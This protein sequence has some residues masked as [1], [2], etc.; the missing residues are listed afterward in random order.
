[1]IKGVNIDA[2]KDTPNEEIDQIFKELRENFATNILLNKSFRKTQLD[3]LRRGLEKKEKEITEAIY[4]DLKLNVSDAYSTN[5]LT[6]KIEIKEMMRNLD[7]WSKP[8]KRKTP[9]ALFPGTS[10]V[11]AQARGVVLVIGSW[12]Y[13]ISTLGPMVA[14]IAAGNCVMIKPSE[15]APATS[16]ILKVLCDE[17]LDT[18]FYRVVE[19][20]IETGRRVSSLPF[21]LICFTGSTFVGKIIAGCA[22]KNLTPCILELGGKCPTIVDHTAKLELCAK[23]IAS[24]KFLNSSQTCVAPD[25]IFVHAKI[26]TKFIEELKKQITKMYGKNPKTSCTYSRLVHE[27]HTNRTVSLLELNKDKII[28][29]DIKEID[30]KQKY[31]P[32][33]LIDEPNTESE[34]MNEEIFGPI[35]PIMTYN[36]PQD[37]IEFINSRPRPLAVYYFG[38]PNSIF[39]QRLRERTFSGAFLTN[40]STIHFTHPELPFGGIGDSGYGTTHGKEGFMQF[41]HLKAHYLRP[42]SSFLDLEVRYPNPEAD[43]QKAL[44]EFKKLEFTFGIF[45]E[46]IMCWAKWIFGILG[47]IGLYFL[48]KKLGLIEINVKL[49]PNRN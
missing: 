20:A 44:K 26:K 40:D 16:K 8:Q 17:Y 11:Q 38:E 27:L 39:S 4:H 49:L 32:P 18:R 29:G 23:R 6:L 46:D 28:Y 13:P 22:A 33:I 7:K 24:N 31:F 2:V 25:Y 47:V 30:V 1:M 45:Y 41:S 21:D 14:A 35:L 3:S 10:Y 42:N 12:N 36:R 15:H 48:A 5:I 37:V 9:V 43:P 19:G 34:L